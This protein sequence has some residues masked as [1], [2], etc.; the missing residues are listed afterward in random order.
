MIKYAQTNGFL[1]GSGAELDSLFTITE[2]AGKVHLNWIA[3]YEFC[4]GGKFFTIDDNLEIDI[5]D[6]AGLHYVYFDEAGILQIQAGG[7][8]DALILT[9]CLVATLLYEAVG[10]SV[11]RLLDE[12]HGADMS[13]ATH[14]HFHET[15]G[16]LYESGYDVGGMDVDGS[17]TDESHAQFDIGAGEHHDEDIEHEFAEDLDVTVHTLFRQGAGGPWFQMTASAGYPLAQG[18][19]GDRLDWNDYNGGSW[20]LQ[21]VPNAQFVFSHYFALG[22]EIVCIMGQATYTNALFARQAANTE[23]A[24]LVTG[25]LPLPEMVPLYSMLWQT[26]DGY[27]NNMAARI[28]S[29]EDGDFVDY[30]QTSLQGIAGTAQGDHENLVGLM[31][32]AV[33]D[34]YHLTAVQ[35]ADLTDGGDTTLHDHDGISENTAARHAEAHAMADHSDGGATGTELEELTDG[36]T[37]ELHD[38]A[39]AVTDHLEDDSE[40]GAFYTKDGAMQLNYNGLLAIQSNTTGIKM[41]DTAGDDPVFGMYDDQENRLMYMSVNGGT[42]YLQNETHGGH[43]YIRGEKDNGDIVNI[44][45]SDPMGDTKFYSRAGVLGFTIGNNIWTMHRG[46]LSDNGMQFYHNGSSMSMTNMF[47]GGITKLIG[48]TESDGTAHNLFYGDP[49]GQCYITYN[50]VANCLTTADGLKIRDTSGVVP[51]LLLQNSGGSTLI[52]MKHTGSYCQINDETNGGAF[53]FTAKKSDST[54][55]WVGFSPDTRAFY[56]SLSK[57]LDLGRSGTPWDTAYADDFENIGDFFFMD[58]RKDTDGKIVP[59]DDGAVIDGIV[60]SGEYDPITGLRIINDSSLPTWL[61]SKHKHAGE[62]KDEAGDVIRTWEKGDICRTIDG[63]P[64]LSLK[65]MISLLMGASRQTNRRAKVQKNQIQILDD[66]R[67]SNEA[68]VQNQM[69]S[70][71]AKMHILQDRLNKLEAAKHSN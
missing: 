19:L 44:L 42:L 45:H 65:T 64:Y 40:V 13:P 59:I 58:D 16:A 30:R 41:F 43:I 5:T 6:V 51:I 1:A 27:A 22:E 35:E 46:G 20:Q 3:D 9:K 57:G 55:Y 52:T 31:G 54:V 7:T 15:I 12:R 29:L 56:S 26:S 36:S 21:E 18:V 70:M 23:M 8:L 48:E 66:R 4:V 28:V 39:N 32:G 17:G 50:G 14:Y 60:P 62:D 2:A 34:H 53:W 69:V 25:G 37:T 49:D 33:D 71:M 38:H 67:I 47:H 68:T 61:V 11:L 63:K 24:S 10:D